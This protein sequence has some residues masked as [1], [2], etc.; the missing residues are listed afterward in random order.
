[1]FIMATTEPHKIP[2]TILSRCMRFDFKLIPQED[3]ENHLKYVLDKT[4]KEYEEEAISAIARAGAGSDRDMLSIADMC[5]SYSSGKLTYDD[6]TS[7]LG[8]ADFNETGKLTGY[9]LSGDESEALSLLE[10]I[11]S[12][13]KSVSVL[14]KDILSFLNAC[15]I[16]K[17]CRDGEKILSLPKK[18]Y[19][20]VQATGKNTDGHRLLRCTEIFARAE[21][22]MKYSSS[23]KI[24]LETALIKASFP[25][26]DYNIDSLISRLNELEKRLSDGRGYAVREEKK[27]AEN[28]KRETEEETEKKEEKIEKNKEAFYDEE[29]KSDGEAEYKEPTESA[30]IAEE[31]REEKT[32]FQSSLPEEVKTNTFG[33]FMRSVRKTSKSSVL[34][35]MCQDLKSRFDKDTFVLMTESSIVYNSLNKEEHIEI[36]REA[37][38]KIGISDFRIEC[39]KV[40]EERLIDRVKADFGDVDIEIK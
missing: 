39:G 9:I 40:N 10:K 17:M 26:A 23:P 14:V 31:K 6:V 36:I 2:A 25:E 20:L 19:E 37:L 12:E 34:F 33:K 28:L 38:E 7:V 8:G 21:G 30:K 24:V 13:G 27:E 5:V 35:V 29:P 32:A 18:M 22:E 3:L 4:G 11:L 15:S 16:A 1:V